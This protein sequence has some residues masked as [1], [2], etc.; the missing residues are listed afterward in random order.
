MKLPPFD[1]RSPSSVDEALALLGE[2]GDDAKVLAGG[3]SLVPLLALR[4]ARPEVLIDLGRVDGLA[5]ITASDGHIR[6]G[7]LARERAAERS[8]EVRQR[9]PLL[10]DALPLIGHAAIRNRGTVGGSVAHGDPAAEIPAVVLA[11]DGEVV[12]RS[13]ARGERVIPAAEFFLGHFTTAL[14]GDELLTEIRLPAPTT[15]TTGTAFVEAVL[16]HGDFAIVG[17]AASVELSG[18]GEIA[19]ARIAL[20]GVASTPVRCAEAEQLLAG[21]A[22]GAETFAAAGEEAARPLDPPSDL[23]GSAAYRKKVAAVLVRRA[24]QQATEKAGAHG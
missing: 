12:A 14:E 8:D 22:P 23:H 10:A 16:R 5:D 3:Q 24:L 11:S 6:I 15:A 1:Y 20:I 4:L 17:A 21:A 7:A 19:A 13:A 2:Y 18:S 9:A